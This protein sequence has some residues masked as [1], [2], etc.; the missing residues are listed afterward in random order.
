MWL[1]GV[2]ND[3]MSHNQSTMGLWKSPEM[4]YVFLYPFHGQRPMQELLLDQPY[5]DW[6]VIDKLLKSRCLKNSQLL[7]YC[8]IAFDN[9]KSALSNAGC[10]QGES[11]RA[12]VVK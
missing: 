1:T 11:G 10:L 4:G 2:K 9:Q 12:G 6:Y 7:F 5:R 3:L 8:D